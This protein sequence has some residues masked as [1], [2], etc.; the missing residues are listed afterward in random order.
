MTEDT[1]ISP[2]K[3]IVPP[4]GTV[5]DILATKG[6]VVH[7]IEPAATVYEAVEKMDE[8]GIGAL[9][10]LEGARL[11]GVLSE[12]DYTRKVI[13]LGRSSREARVYE[14]MTPDVIT[15]TSAT[16]LGDCLQMVTEQ[17]M[18]HL[19]VVDNGCV[20]GVLSIGDLVRAVLDQQAETIQSLSSFID[21]DYPR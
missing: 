1:M 2:T 3:G 4:S 9:I 12:R 13:L 17:R 20:V 19:P 7:S 6:N 11:V 8:Q 18:R 5:A 15:V 10:V 21:S 14:I 16:S